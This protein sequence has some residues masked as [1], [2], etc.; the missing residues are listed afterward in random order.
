VW[1]LTF[2]SEVT[3]RLLV[4]GLTRVLPGVFLRG[5]IDKQP[6][7][8]VLVDQFVLEALEHFQLV[9]VP[10]HSSL[11]V[12]ELARQ[13]NLA[14]FLLACDVFKLIDPPIRLLDQT[15]GIIGQ[16]RTTT[17]SRFNCHFPTVSK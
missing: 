12:G 7:D 3:R 8:A 14:L 5:V 11:G 6:E 9:L 17:H 1:V 2:N 13:L 16:F 10:A 4:I 15:T